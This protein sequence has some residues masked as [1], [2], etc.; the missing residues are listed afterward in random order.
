M[1]SFEH[2]NFRYSKGGKP[3]LNDVLFEL[4]AGHIY[5]LLGKNGV[6]KSTL[7][8]LICGLNPPT[9]GIVK[10][11]GATPFE[12]LPSMLGQIYLLPE[13]IDFP[14][15]NAI[16]YG[17][18]YGAYYPNFSMNDLECLLQRFEVNPLQT[19]KTMSQGQRKKA[20]IAFALAC[21]TPV[22]LMDEPTN[23]LDIPSKTIF[24]KMLS[25]YQDSGTLIIVSTHQV[26]DLERLIDAVII[27]E[28][29]RLVMCTEASTLLEQFHFGV[30]PDDSAEIVYCDD[31]VRGRIGMTKR[32]PEQAVQTLDEFDLETLFNAVVDDPKNFTEFGSNLLKDDFVKDFVQ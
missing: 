18:Y 6:G 21:H 27:L 9:S 23:G 7:F 25:E 11:L 24:R 30:I 17:K 8:R 15:M 14:A 20:N 4:S 19:L 32:K 2:V 26:L 12:R 28:N 29:T 22:L 13:E 3:V 10:T 5:G 16:K 31:T 1:L